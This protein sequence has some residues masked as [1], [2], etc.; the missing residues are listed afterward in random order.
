MDRSLDLLATWVRALL[1]FLVGIASTVI[2]AFDWPA[3]VT[4]IP[5]EIWAAGVLCV[6]LLALWRA[7]G[8]YFD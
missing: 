4:G 2:S 7:L 1:D 8:G 6:L 5:A 3:Q